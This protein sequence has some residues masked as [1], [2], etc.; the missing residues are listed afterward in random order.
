MIAG[1]AIYLT[2]GMVLAVLMLGVAISGG[3]VGRKARDRGVVALAA[4]AVAL[5][6]LPLVF[7]LGIAWLR[8][9]RFD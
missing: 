8:G 4:I 2:V 9:S 7:V 5:L 3:I 1:A 6:W